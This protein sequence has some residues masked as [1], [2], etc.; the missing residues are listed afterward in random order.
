MY[1]ISTSDKSDLSL[2][3]VLFLMLLLFSSCTARVEKEVQ[4]HQKTTAA[5]AAEEDAAVTVAAFNNTSDEVYFDFIAKTSGCLGEDVW[6]GGKLESIRKVMVANSGALFPVKEYKVTELTA[7]GLSTNNNYAVQ[8][9]EQIL[10]GISK[11]N[12][13][14]HL[15]LIDG[16]LELLSPSNSHPVVLAYE[17]VIMSK[18][19]AGTWSCPQ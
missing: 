15:Q 9:K 18:T 5:V 13:V 6:L 12:G 7:V 16:E 8:D 1:K 10:K 2:L 17:P 14:I 11:G 4:E 3:A 19:I